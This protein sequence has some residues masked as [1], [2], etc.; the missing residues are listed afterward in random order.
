VKQFETRTEDQEKIINNFA[1]L[2]EEFDKQRKISKEKEKQLSD[3][4][5]MKTMLLNMDN[6]GN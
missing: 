4:L 1:R 2:Q 3:E 6:S 5:T